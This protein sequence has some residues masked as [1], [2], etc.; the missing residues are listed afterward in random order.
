MFK[1]KADDLIRDTDRGNRISGWSY[2]SAIT[3]LLGVRT[4]KPASEIDNTSNN[5]IFVPVSCIIESTDQPG[6]K[7]GKVDLAESNVS[8]IDENDKII[9]QGGADF[10]ALQE[11]FSLVAKGESKFRTDIRNK[12]IDLSKS[13]I[14]QGDDELIANAEMFRL[15][16]PIT[17]AEYEF[18]RTEKFGILNIDTLRAAFLNTALDPTQELIKKLKDS[19]LAT[20]AGQIGF[21]RPS[22]FDA[23]RINIKQLRQWLAG[24]DVDRPL[25]NKLESILSKSI[26]IS[27]FEE[28]DVGGP[29]G[30]G[31][32]VFDER[33]TNLN[34]K[35]EDDLL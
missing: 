34:A 18:S 2:T 9:V 27:D 29:E 26:R 11:Y 32:H 14:G 17:Q 21:R 23:V 25:W 15:F 20:G 16:W 8:Y 12:T 19:N 22:L 1:E 13:L 10:N 7:V 30:M 24:P 6:I 31:Q 5:E 33:D 3:K 28:P 4:L 35:V